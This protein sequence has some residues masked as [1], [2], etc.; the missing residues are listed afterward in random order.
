MKIYKVNYTNYQN[1]GND[2]IEKYYSTSDDDDNSY[3]VIPPNNIINEQNGGDNEQ[4]FSSSEKSHEDLYFFDSSISENE[5]F[6]KNDEDFD[7]QD[8]GNNTHFV[9]RSNTV[10]SKNETTV[11]FRNKFK[12]NY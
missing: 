2:N 3:F 5:I 11:Q 12:I 10:I 8:G 6:I 1:G 4:Y 7:T 9:E